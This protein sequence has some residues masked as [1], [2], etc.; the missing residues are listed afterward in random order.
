MNSAEF[1]GIF[2][3]AA[4]CD[5]SADWT[6][7]RQEGFFP[8]YMPPEKI[9]KMGD[10]GREI[11]RL[12]RRWDSGDGSFV[13]SEQS[14]DGTKDPSP[15]HTGFPT[16]HDPVFPVPFVPPPQRMKIERY[17]QFNLYGPPPT[18]ARVVD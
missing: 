18:A 10:A 17:H 13:T 4:L 1:M 2:P 12:L 5:Q 14:G 16:T 15:C 8:T 6:L 9:F 11:V 7:A 3:A